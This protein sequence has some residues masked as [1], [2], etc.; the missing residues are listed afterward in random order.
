MAELKHFSKE[1]RFSRHHQAA[2]VT[3]AFDG[4]VGQ[5]GDR[6]RRLLGKGS[7]SGD[8]RTGFKALFNPLVLN[9]KINL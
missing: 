2:Q 1:S 9:R 6:L 4:A 5:A 3:G 8:V 7:K